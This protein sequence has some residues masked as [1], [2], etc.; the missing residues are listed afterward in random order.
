M[1]NGMLFSQELVEKLENAAYNGN[2]PSFGEYPPAQP[3][4]KVIAFITKPE[5]LAFLANY[6]QKANSF[7]ERWPVPPT[8]VLEMRAAIKAKMEIDEMARRVQFDIRYEYDLGPDD[9]IILRQGPLLVQ[10]GNAPRKGINVATEK[11][12]AVVKA[13][14]EVDEAYARL[15]TSIERLCGRADC[16]D[17]S[18]AMCGYETRLAQTNRAAARMVDA[19]LALAALAKQ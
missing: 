14:N 1:S 11:A 13:M 19:E 4:D 7:A 9:P 18:C 3:G 5:L 8:N 6:I 10:E 12:V 2:R 17:E 16:G 15:R